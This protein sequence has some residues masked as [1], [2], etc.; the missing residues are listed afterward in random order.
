MMLLLD[1]AATPPS[2]FCEV[3]YLLLGML[4]VTDP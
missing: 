2:G 4:F 1:A 3:K